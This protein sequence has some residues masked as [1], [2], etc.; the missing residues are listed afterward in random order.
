MCWRPAKS[1][2]NV[3]SEGEGPDKRRKTKKPAAEKKG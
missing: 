1:D 3:S 2:P